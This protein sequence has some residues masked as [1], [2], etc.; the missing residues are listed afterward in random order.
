[1][2]FLLGP[3]IV[4]AM[5]MLPQG[6]ADAQRQ[7][8]KDMTPTQ[9]QMF[10]REGGMAGKCSYDRCYNKC[11]IRRGVEQWSNARCAERCARVRG[12]V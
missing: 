6:Q 11:M 4:V 9:R 1:M 7:R 2:R 10:I 8:T 12:C 3:G 5:L